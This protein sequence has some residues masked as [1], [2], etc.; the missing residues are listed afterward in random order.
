MATKIRLRRMGKKKQAHYR[1]VVADSR[2][3]RDGRFVEKLGYYDPISHP[4]RISVDLER[5]DYWLGEGAEPSPTVASLL[6]KARAGGDEKVALAGAPVAEAEANGVG[7]AEDEAASN[8]EDADAESPDA[9]AE[10]SAGDGSD[11]SADEDG[12]ATGDDVSSD[13]DASASNDA[14][15]TGEGKPATGD[16]ASAGE[17]GAA[18]T[19]E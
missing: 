10:S 17:D 11:A 13:D 6:S 3:P 19:G 15:A 8:G 16:G 18:S 1:I 9:K 14:A 12:A 2:S 7:E 4:A 5:V